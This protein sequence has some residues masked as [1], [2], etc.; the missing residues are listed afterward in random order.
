MALAGTMLA[1]LV[2]C[3]SPGATPEPTRLAARE[4]LTEREVLTCMNYGTNRIL[5]GIGS[6]LTTDPAPSLPPEIP[7]WDL[8]AERAREYGE[9]IIVRLLGS[10]I[11]SPLPSITPAERLTASTELVQRLGA[12]ADM[13]LLCRTKILPAAE[14]LP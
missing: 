5:A 12:D 9:K 14:A 11:P 4:P 1:L 6:A 8:F 2:G 3:S 13:A 10:P 7:E